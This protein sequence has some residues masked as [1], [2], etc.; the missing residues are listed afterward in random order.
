MVV[1]SEN[2]TTPHHAK[3]P[4]I[5]SDNDYRRFFC[6]LS[7]PRPEESIALYLKDQKGPP[8]A[9]I[10]QSQQYRQLQDLFNN[11]ADIPRRPLILEAEADKYKERA[12]AKGPRNANNSIL[13]IFAKVCYNLIRDGQA[14][15]FAFLS[16]AARLHLLLCFYLHDQVTIQQ[17]E[18]CH[19]SG[20]PRHLERLRSWPSANFPQ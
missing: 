10:A 4:L 1:S 20:Q 3:S 18:E 19:R 9:N 7:P 8:P 12:T 17:E 11:S 15:H 5:P 2:V 6:A 13:R 14:Q 16:Y